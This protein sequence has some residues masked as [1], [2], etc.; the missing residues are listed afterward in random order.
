[1]TGELHVQAV[2]PGNPREVYEA[3][4][5]SRSHGEF[6][7]GP[8]EIDPVVGGMF[9]IYD[10]Y[11]T[12]KTLEL[13]PHSRIVQAWRTT[14]FPEGTPDSRLEVSFE[15]VPEGC[16]VTIDHFNLPEDQVEGYKTGWME[17]YFDPMTRYFS[18]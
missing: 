12:G 17:Y 16:R 5:D 14:E 7:G 10:G 4:M 13:K 1:M 8:A 15:S 9:T 3:W 11:I 6:T 2:I 18:R